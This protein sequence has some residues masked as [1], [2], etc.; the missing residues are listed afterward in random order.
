MSTSLGLM[1]SLSNSLYHTDSSKNYEREEKQ[2]A[3]ELSGYLVEAYSTELRYGK[4]AKTRVNAAKKLFSYCRTVK[5][6]DALLDASRYDEN[7]Y[8]RTAARTVLSHLLNKK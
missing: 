1:H 6:A 3:Y 4:T 2:L 7:P 5:D 8:V